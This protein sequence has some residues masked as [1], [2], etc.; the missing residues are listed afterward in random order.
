M[1]R[2]ASFTRRALPLLLLLAAACG[3]DAQDSRGADRARTLFDEPSSGVAAPVAATP[4][5]GDAP[6]VVFLGDSI[7]A[8]LHLAEHQAFPAVMQARLAADGS[9]FELVNASESG[10]TTSGGVTALDWVMRTDPDVV[11]IE[12]GGNDGLRGIALEQIESNLRRMI[13]RA[14][15]GGAHVLLLGVRLPP[16]YGEYGASFDALYPRLARELDVDFEPS[17]MRDVGGVPSM[18]LA[19]GLHPTAMGHERLADNV[20][21]SL[22]RVLRA[23]AAD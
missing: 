21:P 11:V 17:F 19:D 13:E 12:L 6:K 20:L 22:R 2:F 7:G 23:A 3:S 10:R 1:I 14:R 15:E 18:N 16:N 8:G 4:L 9:P 5:P